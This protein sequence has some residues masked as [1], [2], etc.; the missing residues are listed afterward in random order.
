[1]M[2]I[3]QLV[4][5]LVGTALTADAATDCVQDEAGVTIKFDNGVTLTVAAPGGAVTGLTRAE[6]NGHPLRSPG[7]PAHPVFKLADGSSHT[8]CTIESVGAADEAAVLLCNL[9]PKDR[10]GED[11]LRW[12]F[13]PRRE[14]V[15]DREYVGFAYRFEF[16]SP[17]RKLDEI[18]DLGT[19]EIGG[20]IDGKFVQPGRLA[21]REQSFRSYRTWAFATTP[22]FRFQCGEDGMLY[23]VYESVCPA[24][25]WVEKRAGEELLRTFDIVQQELRREGG[26]P[27]RAIMFC[28][29]QGCRGLECVDEYTKVFDHL[30]RQAR[31]E[32]GIADPEYMPI[33]KVP[34]LRE[35]MFEARIPDL[36]EIEA[37]GFKGMWMATFESVDT[38]LRNRK[39][40][41]ASVYS[42]DP[43][44]L[45]GGTRALAKL[46]EE[47]RRHGIH[48]FTWA[49][50]G[51]LRP[52]SEVLE[53]HPEWLLHVPEG[54]RRPLGGSTDLHSGYY[55]YAIGK[56]RD[57]HQ[58]T[59]IDSLWFDSFNAACTP[60]QVRE[61][62]TRYFQ[63]RKAFEMVADTQQAG[64][65]NI[66]LEGAGP[67][68][69]DARTTGYLRVGRPMHYKSAIY[70]YAARTEEINYYYRYL[71][72]KSF[73]M[74]PVRYV[75]W[76]YEYKALDQFPKLR[77]QVRRAN[78][79]W[80]A[81]QDLMEQRHLIAAADDPWK[82]VGVEWT[83]PGEAARAL[84]SYGEFDYPVPPNA[85]VTDV[86][87]DKAIDC[88]GVLR[89]ECCHTYR[90]E[91]AP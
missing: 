23:D 69:Q 20:D 34:Q 31:A 37:L 2:R 60:V 89:T 18:L 56:Y 87:G 70:V 27:F 58:A 5:L 39:R 82:D 63:I 17:I 90:I 41:S 4:L 68:G 51:Q 42:L 66:Q 72:N 73:P 61:D 43:A 49:P 65:T 80:A 74:M 16:S 84:F 76:T 88:A 53:A 62:G 9:T 13:E 25:S 36:A 12:V 91:P 21:T 14:T 48:I 10:K 8:A 50:G 30:E 7:F 79:D 64:I 52:E 71:A 40:A 46:T 59:G 55:D 38:K 67:A 24:I 44:E 3:A 29:D 81:V 33:C 45:L 6:V 26:T 35:E 47:A 85:R 75:L 86:T 77:E 54:K 83:K 22:W 11:S 1:M 78:L 32:F 15:R 19:W 28:A 57:L